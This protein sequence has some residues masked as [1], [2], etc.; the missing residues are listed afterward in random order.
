HGLVGEAVAAGG[1]HE[2]LAVEI[3]GQKPAWEEHQRAFVGKPAQLL[4]RRLGHDGDA[5][6]GLAQQPHLLCRLLAAADDKDLGAIEVGKHGEVAHGP[7][8]LPLGPSAP[9]LNEK[10]AAAPAGTG[11]KGG[12]AGAAHGR[13]AR[14]RIFF[15]DSAID[16]DK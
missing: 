2:A 11:G 10:P 13:W 15:Y 1:E 9:R 16:A 12:S 6:A 3:A 7:R 4:A 5:R 14:D 8:L